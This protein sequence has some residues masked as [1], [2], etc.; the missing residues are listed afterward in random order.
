MWLDKNGQYHAAGRLHLR[1]GHWDRFFDSLVGSRDCIFANTPRAVHR[2]ADVD[3]KAQLELYSFDSSFTY[4]FQ[5]FAPGSVA[6]FCFL[7]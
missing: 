4:V 3:K 1:N 5:K 7:W 2:G 6:Y